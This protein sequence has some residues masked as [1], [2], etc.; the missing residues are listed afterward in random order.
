MNKNK[1]SGDDSIS[2]KENHKSEESSSQTSEKVKL[3]E[4]QKKK[5]IR[6]RKA[7]RFL[8][9]VVLVFSLIALF[10]GVYAFWDT[11]QVMELA[12]SEEYATY[13]PDRLDGMSMGDLKKINDELIGWIDVYGT[14][15]DYPIV[16]GEDNSKYLNTTV[17]GEFST[18]GSIFLDA[19]NSPDFSDFQNIIYGH[20]MAER[21][22]F[23]DMELFKEKEFFDSHKYGAIHRYGKPSKGIE[24]FAFLKTVGT[25]TDILSPA[26][27]M[28]DKQGL[29]EK[30][31]KSADYKRDLDFSDQEN[32]VVL[33]TCDFSITNGRHILVGRL[34]DKVEENI[35]QEDKSASQLDKLLSKVYKLDHIKNLFIIWIILVLLYLIYEGI[36][37]KKIREE[38]K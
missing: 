21:K 19:G 29:I 27:K 37:R 20:Y 33:D 26:K 24:F 18:A 12:S 13:K 38:S 34:T 2:N 16:Q 30:I 35:Y 5:L 9:Y 10:I 4:D 22:M 25:D 7:S 6:I 32:L 23:G 14:N 11:K 36:S 17:F 15:I 8:D 1:G 3:T 28:E 31:Y